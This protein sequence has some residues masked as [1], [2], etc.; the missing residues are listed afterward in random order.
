MVTQLSDIGLAVTNVNTYGEAAE[1]PQVESRDMLQK[2]NLSDGNSVPL[3]G[4][5]AKFSKTP[6]KIHNAAPRL[7]ENNVE[8]YQALGLGAEELEQLEKEGVI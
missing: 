8:I 7:G 5:A 4:P 1:H 2:V 6:T 3:T